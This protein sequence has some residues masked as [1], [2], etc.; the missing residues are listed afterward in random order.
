MISSA[1]CNTSKSKDI[2]LLKSKDT[3]G[4]VEF[5]SQF[6]TFQFLSDSDGCCISFSLES[7]FTSHTGLH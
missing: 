3:E 2:M 1:A 6:Q 4:G 7:Y 5:L